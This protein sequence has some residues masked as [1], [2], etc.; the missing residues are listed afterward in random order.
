VSGLA[1]ADNLDWAEWDTRFVLFTGKGGVGKTTIASTA[2]VA[3]A[4]AGRTVLLV[5]TDPA[6]NLADVFQTATGEETVPAPSVARL[7]LM[8]IDPQ[9]AADAYKERV[10]GP[11]RDVVTPRELAAMEE[12]LAGAC[13]VEVAAFDA[14]T[15][16]VADPAAPAGYDHVVFDTAPTGHT[17]RLLALPAA[18]SHYLVANP[19]ETT[20]LGPLA[21]LQGQRPLYE[22]AV[23]VLADPTTTTLV[24]VARPER[25]ALAEAARARSEL[26]ELGLTNQRL[27]V[28][29]LLA[30]PREGDPT[31]E[32][33]AR[34]ERDA[35]A[36]LPAG[37]ADMPAAVVALAAID[38]VGVDALRALAHPAAA[39]APP[40]GGHAGLVPTFHDVDDLVDAL[41]SQGSGVTL[42]TGKGGVGKT[43]IAVRIAAGLARRGLPVHL[44]TTD[45]AGRLPRPGGAELPDTVAVSRIDSHA[46]TE[47]YAAEQLRGTS[48]NQRELAA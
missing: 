17:L 27:I 38:L 6:S 11:Y 9:G 36:V 45:P 3:L 4:D 14:F 21:G 43:T 22:R 34:R 32:A 23:A 35:L 33:Y 39:A 47:R 29:G 10:I 28:N 1:D 48:D 25:A 13:T 16:L 18:W 41:A 44:A 24:L 12:Q 5:S 7:D 30:D 26:A 40:P 42:V 20:C 31:A 8:D 19:E 2:A 37:L 15:R 46:E